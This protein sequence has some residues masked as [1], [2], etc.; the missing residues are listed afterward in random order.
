MPTADTRRMSPLV[1]RL[2]DQIGNEKSFSCFSEKVSVEQV[3]FAHA[4]ASGVDVTELLREWTGQPTRR[5]KAAPKRASKPKVDI[6]DEP[7]T[8]TCPTCDGTGRA[9]D[10]GVCS[11]CDGAGRVDND[12]DNDEDDE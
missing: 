9:K 6:D 8:R 3:I 12:P 7:T 2:R 5:S 4:C 1:R 11:Q 10:G